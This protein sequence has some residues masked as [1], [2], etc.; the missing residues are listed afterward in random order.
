MDA[1]SREII[2]CVRGNSGITP[3]ELSSRLGVSERTLRNRVKQTNTALDGCASVTL[4]RGKGYSFLVTN[5]ETLASLLSSEEPVCERRL[6]TTP[7]DRSRFILDNLLTRQEWVTLDELAG[8]LCISR[9]TVSNDLKVVEA[10]FEEYGLVIE[11]RPCYGIRVKGGEFARRICLANSIATADGCA[12]GLTAPSMSPDEQRRTFS[13]I[14]ACVQGVMAD[15]KTLHVNSLVFRNLVVHI[16]VAYMR[17][18]Q[19]FSIALDQDGLKRLSGTPEYAVAEKIAQSIE[20]EFDMR[21][22][23]DE[24]GYVAIHLAGK[25][26]LQTFADEDDERGIVISDEVWD[27]VSSMLE[28]VWKTF[29]YDFRGDLE[30]HMNLARHVVPLSYRLRYNMRVENPLLPDIRSRFP[31]A[32]SMAQDSGSLLVE[33][34]GAPL[35]AGETGYIALAFA[36]AL[37]RQR[38]SLPKKSIL[39]VCATGMGSARLLEHIYRREFGDY[40]G[41]IF[42]CDVNHVDDYDFSGI[43][44]VFTTVPLAHEL[45]VPVREVKLFLESSDVED[46]R[47][48][49]RDRSEAC[50]FST[51]FDQALFFPHLSFSTKHD[52]LN[53]LCEQVSHERLV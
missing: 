26:T 8:M 31:L 35:S 14:E 3:E 51:R 32:Y 45:P 25:E 49:F 17:C 2:A 38:T 16:M 9:A 33:H 1:N 13:R 41:D 43:D 28:L 37:E 11:R 4:H 50:D 10:R 44:Y 48:F 18:D 40:I 15:D 20:H 7:A 12:E 21:F 46:T 34:Y 53:Y 24:V 27:L 5:E 47:K 22:P 39:M 42:M 52:V 6:P 19:G 36:L 30:L 29:H 23:V